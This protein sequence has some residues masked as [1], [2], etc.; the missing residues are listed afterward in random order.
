MHATR[1]ALFSLDIE[2]RWR[3]LDAFNHV[4]NAN[5]LTYLEE[6]RMVWLNALP[7]PWKD[8]RVSPLLAAVQ[9]NFRRPIGWPETVAVVLFAGRIGRT[10][11]TLEHRIVSAADAGLVYAD[12]EAVMV[13]AD[14]RTG[15]SV[16]LPEVVRRGASIPF[17][18]PG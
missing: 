8:D 9:V 12:G 1:T 7:G 18:E 3:D 17:R 11:I 10:S 14:T 6:A 5:F 13:W 4:N 16:E 2:V 15:K